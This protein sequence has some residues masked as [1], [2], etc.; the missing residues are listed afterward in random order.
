M[1]KTS[2]LATLGAF[3]LLASCASTYKLDKTIWYNTSLV[4]KNGTNALMTT[5]LYFFSSDT[6]D[7]Y[8]S[9][10]I[11]TTMVVEPFKFA[12]GTYSVSGNPSKEAEISIDAVTI[13]NKDIKYN[14]A[15][16]KSKA[17]YLISPDSIIKVY[18]K[19]KEVKIK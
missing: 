10:R 2:I 3:C 7:I 14:G 12:S 1:K 18:G 9:V 11:D 17:M 6:V 8:C 15:F 19:L 16:H 4:E 13:D 5:S